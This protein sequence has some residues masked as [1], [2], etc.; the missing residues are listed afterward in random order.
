VTNL[1]F[2]ELTLF[3]D[4]QETLATESPDYLSK[5]L[6]TY[7]GNKRSLV[8]NLERAIMEARSRL[9]GRKLSAVDLFSGSG[10]V[11]R[12]LKKHTQLLIANDLE[13][14]SEVANRCFLSNCSAELL[15]GVG[16]TVARLNQRAEAGESRDG[17][18]REMYSP[19][20][21]QKIQPGE[22]VFYTNDNARRLDFYAQE[23]ASMDEP[24]RSLILGPLLSRASM[25]A[26]TS[27]VFKGFYKDKHTG[28]GKFGAAAGDALKRILQPISLEVPILSKFQTE[29][30]IHR[31]DANALVADLSGLDLAY[32][33]PP[34]NQHPYGSN[35]FMLNLL[36][37]YRRPVDFSAV[38]G[39]PTDWN[40]SGY[41]VRKQS[42]SLMRDLIKRIPARFLLVSFNAEGYIQTDDLRSALEAHGRVDEFVIPY[43]TFRG[44]R[45]LR[46]RAIHVNEHLF[47][48]DREG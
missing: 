36:V 13:A 12:L 30:A 4:D 5:Q 33:D 1:T 22:R 38:S 9:G 19:A 20:D 28:V 3:G 24:L 41:N 46:D 47:L 11:A 16:D 32:I 26:N 43:N 31:K 7:I 45:N 27:G 18:I 34:Y 10:F 42:L 40:R 25:H 17:F 29:S 44:S 15:R 8:T 35:Y 21:D 14:Y 37:D 2:D 6:I 23:I 39:I 48:M